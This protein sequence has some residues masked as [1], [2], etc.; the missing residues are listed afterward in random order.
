[1]PL[2]DYHW[3]RVKLFF[4][5]FWERVGLQKGVALGPLLVSC[6]ASWAHFLKLQKHMYRYFL[7]IQL[8]PA[9]KLELRNMFFLSK[10]THSLDCNTNGELLQQPEKH[11]RVGFIYT[12]IVLSKA[13]IFTLVRA[14]LFSWNACAVNLFLAKI[15]LGIFWVTKRNDTCRKKKYV[16]IDK[17]KFFLEV[18]LFL[19]RAQFSFSFLFVHFQS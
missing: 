6:W 15:S 14:D 18:E 19:F 16:W 7:F 1:M 8:C 17:L 13:L 3:K 2:Y 4:W 10:R 5:F 11:D 9:R 12:S